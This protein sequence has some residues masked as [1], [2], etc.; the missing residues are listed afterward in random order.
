ML[1]GYKTS[2]EL[3][4]K[5]QNT[6]SNGQLERNISD[7]REK[8]Q[9]TAS[10]KPLFWSLAIVQAYPAWQTNVSLI[11]FFITALSVKYFNRIYSGFIT[12]T[13]V[14]KSEDASVYLHQRGSHNI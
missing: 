7:F 14:V 13:A 11:F 4:V 8:S 9:L 6:S 1:Q 3:Y 5:Y 12:D 10:S 2:R